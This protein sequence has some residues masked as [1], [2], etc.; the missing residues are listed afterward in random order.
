MCCRASFAQMQRDFRR[1]QTRHE[2]TAAPSWSR[3]KGR[4]KGSIESS[5]GCTMRR[6]LPERGAE[7]NGT[8]SSDRCRW[9]RR[10]SLVARR[11]VPMGW[12]GRWEKTLAVF[13]GH[14]GDAGEP[15]L[16]CQVRRTEDIL[17]S[18]EL[19]RGCWGFGEQKKGPR[20][21]PGLTP[22]PFCA[23]PASSRRN[24]GGGRLSLAAPCWPA[25]SVCVLVQ[26][27]RGRGRE[28]Q[29]KH[30]Q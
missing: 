5:S 27:T 18:Q 16:K 4:L 7:A 17:Y 15:R 30:S 24:G 8:A 13:C 29:S 11:V 23:S 22:H 28:E 1:S 20:L 10:A 25:S 26:R 2:G 14:A 6:P 3:R 12:G 9:T 21:V 19:E